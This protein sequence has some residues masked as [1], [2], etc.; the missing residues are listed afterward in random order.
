[1]YSP[2]M[3]CFNHYGRQYTEECNGFCSYAKAVKS[4]EELGEKEHEILQKVQKLETLLNNRGHDRKTALA[5]LKDLSR[6]MYPNYD[7]FGTKTLV[8]NRSQ[9]EKIRA[10]YLDTH[11]EE[12][13]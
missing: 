6:D 5:V 9:F 10:K 12:Q 7:L 8:I 13:K 4:L 2:C 1:M 3:E 11:K